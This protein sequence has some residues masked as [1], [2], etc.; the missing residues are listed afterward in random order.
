ML[1]CRQS[2]ERQKNKD[3]GDESQ[4]LECRQSTVTGLQSRLLKRYFVYDATHNS[5]LS[6]LCNLY[7]S[8]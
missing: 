2:R 7:L 8:V 1:E 6:N 5:E 4:K 3:E